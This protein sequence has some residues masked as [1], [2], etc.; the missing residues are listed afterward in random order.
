MQ[1]ACLGIPPSRQNY[2]AST[3]KFCE[4]ANGIR[5]LHSELILMSRTLEEIQRKTQKLITRSGDKC[6]SR[7][8]IVS[9]ITCKSGEVIP[10]SGIYIQKHPHLPRKECILV[11]G[12]VTPWCGRCGYELRFSLVRAVPHIFELPEFVTNQEPRKSLT[13]SEALRRR[14]ASART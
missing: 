7:H 8:K 1:C 11:R 2:G 14:A 10:V 4:S 5:R 12:C 13:V 3:G 9:A 6:E